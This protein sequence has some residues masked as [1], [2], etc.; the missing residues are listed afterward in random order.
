LQRCGLTVVLGGLRQLSSRLVPLLPQVL[1]AAP[2]L[3]LHARDETA[4]LLARYPQPVELLLDRVR[5]LSQRGGARDRRD[6]ETGQ[7]QGQPDADT[8][9]DRVEPT[10][11]YGAAS[12][13]SRPFRTTPMTAV[14]P[15]ASPLPSN[16]IVPVT[17]SNAACPRPT[18]AR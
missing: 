16:A 7:E 4:P 8:R 13:T 10:P 6:D 14:L 1:L 5:D 2:D 3:F 9:A 12:V 18:R 17:P 15:A 11:H